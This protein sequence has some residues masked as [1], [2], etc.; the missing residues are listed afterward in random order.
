MAQSRLIDVDLEEQVAALRK[1]LGA[2]KKMATRRGSAFYDEASDT[3]SDYL[4]DLSDR[5]NSYLPTFR[6]QAKAV[7]RAA[8]DHP[9][10]VAAVGLVVIGLVA[11]LIM[12]SRPAQEPPPQ[13]RRPR[14]RQQARGSRPAK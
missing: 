5:L 6:K 3:V 10:V 12:A 11:S 13:V 9:A 2:L 14:Q 7:E 8:F 1:E 4:S